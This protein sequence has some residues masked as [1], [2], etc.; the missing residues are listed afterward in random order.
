MTIEETEF[1]SGY[2][3]QVLVGNWQEERVANTAETVRETI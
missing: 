2:G 1:H 3:Q